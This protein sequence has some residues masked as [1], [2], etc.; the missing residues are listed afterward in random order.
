MAALIEIFDAIQKVSTMDGG[1]SRPWK[2]VVLTASGLKPFVVKLFTTNNLEQGG[3]TAKEYICNILASEMDLKVPTPALI[4]FNEDFIETLSSEDREF[5]RSRDNG[6]K[7]GCEFVE[8]AISF[9]KYTPRSVLYRYDV[10]KIYGFDNLILNMD[11]NNEKP[12]ML[13]K[14]REC[15]VIDHEMALE[16][17]TSAIRD[18]RTG[19]TYYQYVRHIFFMFLKRS[20]ESEVGEFIDEFRE[21]YR[22]VN[23]QRIIQVMD[24][25]GEIGQYVKDYEHIYDYLH[26]SRDLLAK[27]CEKLIFRVPFR[28]DEQ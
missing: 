12:N 24:E 13:L 18:L 11:R 27:F 1:S 14:N 3:S 25:L 26:L 5:L 7:F 22:S 10:G 19:D 23:L 16:I 17:P 28:R 9:N 20:T 21:A 6:L 4:R 15:Y 8:G 2:V